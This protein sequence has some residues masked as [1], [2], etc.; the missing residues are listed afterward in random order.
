MSAYQ[1]LLARFGRMQTMGQV[2][3]VLHWDSATCLPEGAAE[4]RGEQLAMIAGLCHEW[5]NDP[6][7][8][9]LLSAAE[10]RI[11]RLG[12]GEPDADAAGLGGGDVPARTPRDRN[13]QSDDGSGTC[14][15]Y[16]EK[17]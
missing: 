9:D 10:T 5:I 11:C 1:E 16:G 3:S 12:R 2:S 15:A 4:L 6:A 17:E 13:G 14:L 7:L 8:S